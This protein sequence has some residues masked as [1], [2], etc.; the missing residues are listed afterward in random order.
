MRRSIIGVRGGDLPYSLNINI[1]RP[2]TTPFTTASRPFPQFVNVTQYHLDGSLHYNSLQLEAKRSVGSLTFDV[3]Y[4]LQTSLNN[5][6][7]LENP[8]DVLSHWTN[9]SQ[10]RKHYAVGTAIWN[11]PAGP[12][13]RYLSHASKP[14][15]L[16]LG[17]WKIYWISYLASGAYFSPSFSGSSP[18]NTGVNGGLPDLVGDPTNVPDG[19]NYKTW[20]NPAAFAVPP[21][22]RF[23]NALPNSLTGQPL[24]THHVSIAKRFR[25]TEKLSYT[26]TAAVSNVFNHPAFNAPPANISVAGVGSF[27]STVGVFQS[28]ERAGARQMTLKG[29]FEF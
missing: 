13:L 4:S 10:T 23:G 24:N 6:S 26:F 20:F 28:N 7:D 16:I 2:S 19:R 21:A 12:G 15:E 11:I 17:N 1:P 27:T 18:S 25:V 22:G 3:N 29:R 5:F 14:V 8:Y 9:T